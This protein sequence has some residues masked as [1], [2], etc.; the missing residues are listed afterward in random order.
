MRLIG[1][2]VVFITMDTGQRVK[3]DHAANLVSV[4]SRSC[5][6]KLLLSSLAV[7]IYIQCINN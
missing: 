1:S 4:A 6:R 5:L 2:S 3:H 7:L